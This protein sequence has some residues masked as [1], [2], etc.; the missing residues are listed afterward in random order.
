MT[1]KYEESTRG[2]NY[3]LEAVVNLLF[4]LFIIIQVRNLLSI[5]I[6]GFSRF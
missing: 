5:N 4:L 6:G 2:K 1:Y 3:K